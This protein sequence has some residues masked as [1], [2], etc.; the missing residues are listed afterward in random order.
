MKLSDLRFIF[1]F[2]RRRPVTALIVAGV[3]TGG[4]GASIGA[5]ATK[6]MVDE[7]HAQAMNRIS[8]LEHDQQRSQEQLDRVESKIDKIL[9][10]MH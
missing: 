3:L 1:E 7:K 8:I 6:G 2:A 4:S 5:F 9:L 10:R